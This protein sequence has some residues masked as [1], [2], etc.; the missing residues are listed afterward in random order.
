MEMVYIIYSRPAGW[1]GAKWRRVS[2]APMCDSLEEALAWIEQH[3][4]WAIN[5]RIE[6]GM[7]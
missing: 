6:R 1:R 4:A 7:Q 5:Y 3:R 2:R